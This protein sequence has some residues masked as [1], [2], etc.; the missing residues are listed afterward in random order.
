VSAGGV[1]IVAALESPVV[2][3]VSTKSQSLALEAIDEVDL[4]RSI[5]L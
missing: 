2:V 4:T 3:G 5:M 1:T